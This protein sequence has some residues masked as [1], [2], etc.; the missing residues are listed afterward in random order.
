MTFAVF[1]CLH[2]LLL[3]LTAT[4]EVWLTAQI[5]SLLDVL[6]GWVSEAQMSA[7]PSTSGRSLSSHID[8]QLPIHHVHRS[9]RVQI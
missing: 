1:A 4:G 3:I 9:S 6:K 5:F 8:S 2:K 7:A